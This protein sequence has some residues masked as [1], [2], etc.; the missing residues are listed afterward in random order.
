MPS[1]LIERRYADVSNK[2][3]R[4]LDE[5]ER[6]FRRL[7]LNERKLVELRRHHAR[8]ARKLTERLEGEAAPKPATVQESAPAAAPAPAQANPDGLDP[9]DFL[10]RSRKLAGDKRDEL[11]RAAIL[12]EQAE[13]KKLRAQNRADERKAKLSGATRRMPLTGKAALAAIRGSE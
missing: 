7:T 6:L 5:R 12:A 11:A 13:R 8:L 2:I 1:T 10:D 3:M 4:A 9:P